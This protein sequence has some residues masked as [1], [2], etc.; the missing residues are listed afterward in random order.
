[1]R[2]P[3]FWHNKWAANQIGFHLED[4]NPLLIRF[5]SDLAPKHSEKVLVP[6]CGKSE[7][8]IWLANQHD[9]VQGVELSQ[10]AVRSFFGEHFYTPTVTRLNAQHELYQFDELTLFTGD[11]FTAPVESVDLV[12]DRAALVAL[13]EEMRAEYAQRVLQLLKPGGR[14]LLVSMDYVQTELLGPPF[15]V[16]EAEIRTLFM[17]CEVRRVYQDT[18]IDPHLNK[19]TQAGLSRFAEE[20]WVIEK[21]E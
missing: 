17:G 9:S 16:P 2:D 3:E 11:F 13:P 14:I 12:Y 21:G 1:M 19:R 7:D 15:S 5:W 6:L 18:S 8:L 10:I 20:V 4:V